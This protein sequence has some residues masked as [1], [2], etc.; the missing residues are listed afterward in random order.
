MVHLDP[1]KKVEF[2]NF[3]T[4][5]E[6]LHVAHILRRDEHKILDIPNHDNEGSI[7]TGTTSKYNV[8][9]LLTHPDIRP[10]EIPNRLFALP[11]FTPGK[12]SWFSELWVQSWGNV[13][14]QTE[15]LKVHTHNDPHNPQPNPLI[16]CSIYLD[17]LDPNYTH[18][19]GIPQR[20]ERG[21]LHVAGMYHEHEVKQNIHTTPRISMAM[22]IYWNEPEITHIETKRF[23]HIKRPTFI[24][25]DH[26]RRMKG[27]KE[28]DIHGHGVVREN[29]SNI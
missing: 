3:L 23:L 16:A 27:K 13:L 24:S 22:D 15:D 26:I 4:E 11:I 7:Y 20:N 10:L 8:Y 12:D 18:W 17:G 25:E 6:S 21:T 29:E 9:N 14:H 5:E 28:K 2:P 19:D 1:Y